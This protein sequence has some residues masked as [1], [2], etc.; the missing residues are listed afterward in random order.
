M[1]EWWRI[2]G[3]A[4]V[5]LF[6]GVVLKELGFKG[7]RLV[8]LLG[9]VS[10]LCVFAVLLRGAYAKVLIASIISEST[11]VS[12]GGGAISSLHPVNATRDEHVRSMQR[13]KLRAL[14]VRE[15]CAF[16]MNLFFLLKGNP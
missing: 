15:C 3:Y 6:L 11:T 16:I 4:L 13:I 14:V 12:L 8:V 10:L 1:T 2:I 9:T 5:T 7:T